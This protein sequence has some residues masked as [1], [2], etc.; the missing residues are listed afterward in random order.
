MKK[1]DKRFR[2][3]AQGLPNPSALSETL[4]NFKLHP[5][6]RHV[7]MFGFPLGVS[8]RQVKKMISTSSDLYKLHRAYIAALYLRSLGNAV[9]NFDEIPDFK[10]LQKIRD[11]NWFDLA[12]VAQASQ[13][14]FLVSNDEDQ[15]K[16]CNFLESKT[17]IKAKAIKLQDFLN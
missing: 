9:A 15:R 7:K 10:F 4:V 5:Y 12:I 2:D 11:G 14:D 6:D 16:I 1:L 13:F 8:C 3:E 17:I